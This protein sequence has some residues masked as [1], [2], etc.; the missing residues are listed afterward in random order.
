[1]YLKNPNPVLFRLPRN[2]IRVS[3]RISGKVGLG[4]LRYALGLGVLGFWVLVLRDLQSQSF[5]AFGLG[6]SEF[7][8]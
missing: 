7:R 1:M 4:F 6:L 2:S 5:G 3:L 8:V